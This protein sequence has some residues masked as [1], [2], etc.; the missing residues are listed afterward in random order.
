MILHSFF[1]NKYIFSIFMSSWGSITG[2]GKIIFPLASVSRLALVLTQPPVHWVSGVLSLGLK[3]SRGVTLT[4]RLHLVL[5]SRICRSCTSSP[6]KHL[7]GVR[8]DSFSFLYIYDVL[9][10]CSFRGSVPIS[11]L[12]P[13]NI[14]CPVQIHW[15]LCCWGTYSLHWT[16][17]YC[18]DKLCYWDLNLFSF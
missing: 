13:C 7:H 17:V 5:R 3:H 11:P 15:M 8:W 10:I 14:V 18:V 12:I 1:I 2:R 16:R 4:S 9:F 6:P